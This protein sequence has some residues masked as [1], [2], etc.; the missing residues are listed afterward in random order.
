MVTG[1]DLIDAGL[2]PGPEF[3]GWLA[4]ARLLHFSGVERSRAL[5]QVLA[6]ARRQRSGAGRR[7]GEED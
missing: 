3:S 7:P 6:E 1:Q 4:R 5:S 2:V